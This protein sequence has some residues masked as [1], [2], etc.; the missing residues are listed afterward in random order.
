MTAGSEFTIIFVSQSL[1]ASI[2]DQK[3]W[4]VRSYLDGHAPVIFA[5]IWARGR[6]THTSRQYTDLCFLG[7]P[8]IEALASCGWPHQFASHYQEGE[9]FKVLC[10]WFQC[11]DSWKMDNTG[12]E[13]YFRRIQPGILQQTSLSFSHTQFSQHQLWM[14]RWRQLEQVNSAV[15]LRNVSCSISNGSSA[16]GLWLSL[17]CH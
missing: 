4:N 12:K 2:I 10:C 11:M 3:H 7:M 9:V 8:E 13:I 15:C 16:K 14:G 1:Q 5:E 6:S 17:T